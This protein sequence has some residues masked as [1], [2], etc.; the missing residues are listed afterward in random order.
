MANSQE[1]GHSQK[2][3][4]QPLWSGEKSYSTNNKACSKPIQSISWPGSLLKNFNQDKSQLWE[5]PISILL[6]NTDLKLKVLKLIPSFI[7]T[8]NES[9]LYLKNMG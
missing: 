8:T 3:K 2:P 6:S 1:S 5:K 4:G 9:L 7:S